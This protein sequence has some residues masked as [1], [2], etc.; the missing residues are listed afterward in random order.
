MTKHA[1]L[2]IA[3]ILGVLVGAGATH[4]GDED[5]TVEEPGDEGAE[6]VDQDDGADIGAPASGGEEGPGEEGLGGEPAEPE[7]GEPAVPE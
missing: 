6:S 4:A 7:G 2:I 1:K 3:F 5:G